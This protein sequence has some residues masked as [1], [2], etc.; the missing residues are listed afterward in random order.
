[1]SRLV[2]HHG[3][4]QVKCVLPNQFHKLIKITA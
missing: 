1:M 2:T 4:I 3:E